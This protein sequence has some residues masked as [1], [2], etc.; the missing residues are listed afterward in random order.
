MRV[1]APWQAYLRCTETTDVESVW[2]GLVPAPA[3]AAVADDDCCSI[4]QNTLAELH[5][6][7][8]RPVIVEGPGGV[9]QVYDFASLLTWYRRHGTH[10]VQVA[11]PLRLEDVRSLLDV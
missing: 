11:R 6:G 4:S 9:W 8:G 10:P 5:A 7:G 3:T 1:W 2:R